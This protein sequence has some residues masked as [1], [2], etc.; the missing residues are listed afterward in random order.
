MSAAVTLI[1]MC[2]STT[3]LDKLIRINFVHFETPLT[4][5][6]NIIPT[7]KENV[8]QKGRF[9]KAIFWRDRERS[10]HVKLI[11]RMTFSW[12][13]YSSQKDN[14]IRQKFPSPV[15]MPIA[16][17]VSN[18]P[19]TK[20]TSFVMVIRKTFSETCFSQVFMSNPIDVCWRGHFVPRLLP[21]HSRNRV[22][23]PG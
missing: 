7:T 1:S 13:R 17:V 16:T 23:Q 8:P 19:P 11:S 21:Q 4:S 9:Q 22:T 15:T 18:P 3:C 12:K 10:I 2:R 14:W 20:Q 6:C 5:K